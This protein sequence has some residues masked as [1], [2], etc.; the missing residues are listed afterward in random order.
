[1]RRLGLQGVVRGKQVNTTISDKANPW[2][3]DKANR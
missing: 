2:P 1:M 3:L